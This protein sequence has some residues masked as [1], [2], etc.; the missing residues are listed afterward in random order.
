[1]RKLLLVLCAVCLTGAFPRAA[2]AQI[3]VFGGYS[4]MRPSVVLPQAC[5]LSPCPVTTSAHPN[6]NGWELTG[7]YNA[8][9]WLGLAADFT[10][11]YGAV[12]GASTNVNTYLFGPQ[13]RF[14]APVSPFAHALVGAAHEMVGAGTSSSTAFAAAIGA[15]IDVHV[16][17]FISFRPIQIDYLVTRLASGTQS[18]PRGSAGLVLHF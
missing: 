7:V 18:Q 8:Y 14:D 16:A 1:M 2:H 4:Y 5:G 10:G 13:V 11:E 6:L 17:R 12:N 9:H 15:G 3:E